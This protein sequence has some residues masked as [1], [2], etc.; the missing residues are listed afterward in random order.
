MTMLLVS[1]RKGFALPVVLLA[2]F[3]LVGA[4]AA[5]TTML[6]GERSADDATFQ[7]QAAAGFAE[8][9][10]Q[11]GL[12]NRAG[13]GLSALPGATPDSAR[14]TLD[15]G[16]ADIITTRLRAPVGTTVPGIYYI[17]S[18]GVRTASGVRGGGNSVSYATA[19][20]SFNT[21]NFTVQSAMTGVNGINKNGA[22]GAISGVDQCPA[23]QGGGQPTLPAVA[24]PTSPGY[25]GSQAP[26]TGN[27]KV[28]SIGADKVAAADA[29]PI[30][31]DAIV[32]HDAI[33]A[34]FDLPA[35]GTGFP[36]SAWFSADTSRYPTIIVR[37]GPDP[38]T[39]FVLSAFGRGLLIVF[40]DL[41]LNGNT[42]GWDGL[43]LV[44][45]RLTSNGT[46]QVRGGTVTGL[47]IKL[48][49]NIEENDVNELNGTKQYLYHSCFVRRS[50]ESIN[51]SS[52]RTYHATWANSFPTY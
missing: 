42:A 19:F 40:G 7:A 43:I 50:M 24:V 37:N 32:N 9:G 10:L 36:T 4:L 33:T 3:L 11:Q 20:A 51:S 8:A 41:R 34:D 16:Y 52:L 22:A 29:V 23:A 18:R 14:L 5:G 39:Q 47:N 27:P 15:G 1:T 46:N 48:G 26:L 25:T 35:D 28:Q 49:F 38:T 44:G 21:V 30:D 12:S 2:V 17:R 31:W 13:L 6:S 45:G